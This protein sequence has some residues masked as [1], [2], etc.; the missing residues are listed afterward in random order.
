[1][2]VYCGFKEEESEWQPKRKVVVPVSIRLVLIAQ[3]VVWERSPSH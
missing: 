1:V 2:R 3:A